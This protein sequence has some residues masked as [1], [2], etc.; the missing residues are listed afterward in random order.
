MILINK[1]RNISRLQDELHLLFLHLVILSVCP[2]FFQCLCVS[3][4]VTMSVFVFYFESLRFCNWRFYV[5]KI[6]MVS[7]SLSESTHRH[8]RWVHSFILKFKKIHINLIISAPRSAWL[9]GPLIHFQIKKKHKLAA[10]SVG[11]LIHLET[12]RIF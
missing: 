8:G 3:L 5:W 2:L 10:L 4:I 6:K 1:D 11:P 9:V 12:F 7:V